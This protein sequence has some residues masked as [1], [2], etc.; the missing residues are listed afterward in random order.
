MGFNKSE[1]IRHD[2]GKNVMPLITK[3]NEWVKELE[4]RKKSI[5]KKLHEYNKELQEQIDLCMVDLENFLTKKIDYVNKSVYYDPLNVYDSLS[6]Y[7]FS[8]QVKD[9]PIFDDVS[10]KIDDIIGKYSYE[11]HW[12]TP[13]GGTHEISEVKELDGSIKIS[14]SFTFYNLGS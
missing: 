8:L 9:V 3:Y 7:K 11:L 5:S 12:Q 10:K 14:C 6:E 4:D 1:G 2:I 13:D